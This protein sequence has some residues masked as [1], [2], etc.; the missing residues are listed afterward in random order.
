MIRCEPENP[1]AQL[2]VWTI[3]WWRDAGDIGGF[4]EART[5]SDRT[6]TELA[7]FGYQE[8]GHTS[9]PQVW[10]QDVIDALKLAA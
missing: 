3:S 6:P 10:F 8:I 2:V 7:K 1:H 5:Y 9:N 4:W